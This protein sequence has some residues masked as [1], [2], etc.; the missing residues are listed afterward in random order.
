MGEVVV[1][2]LNIRA[3]KRAPILLRS[4]FEFWLLFLNILIFFFP[5]GVTVIL[6]IFTG[7]CLPWG[8]PSRRNKNPAQVLSNGNSK[9]ISLGG[10]ILAKGKSSGKTSLINPKLFK[11]L[12]WPFRFQE[13][14]ITILATCSISLVMVMNHAKA[15][16]F[17]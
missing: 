16:S 11:L 9:R 12:K 2:W 10:I 4:L 8:H 3:S 14:A 15:N 6:S 5:L 17:R 1:G 13:G 7:H